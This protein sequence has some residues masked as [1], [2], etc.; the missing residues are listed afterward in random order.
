MDRGGMW[1]RKFGVVCG[2]RFVMLRVEV[3]VAVN[4]GC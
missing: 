4:V 2:F 3:D 1:G